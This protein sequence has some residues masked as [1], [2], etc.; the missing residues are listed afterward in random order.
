MSPIATRENTLRRTHGLFLGAGF[1][2]L[3]GLCLAMV[4]PY[5]MAVSYPFQ[6]AAAYAAVAACAWRAMKARSP[7][8]LGWWLV[9]LSLLLWAAGLSVS[10]WEDLGQHATVDFAKLSDL[11]YFLFGVPLLVA[12]SLPASG[13]EEKLFAWLDGLQAAITACAIYVAMFSSLPFVH[14]SNKPISASLL[15]QAYN[16]ENL[17][18]ASAATLRLLAEQTSGERRRLYGLLTGFLWCYAICAGWYNQTTIALQEQVGLYDLLVALPVTV[19]AVGALCVP[20]AT[21]DGDYTVEKR[22]LSELIDGIVPVLYTFALLTLGVF[23][24][25]THFYWGATALVVALAVFVIRSTV[26]HSRLLRSELAL[27][28]AHDRLEEIALTDALT[29]VANRRSFDRKLQEEWSRS[30]RSHAPLSLLLIDIDFFKPL[31]DRLGHQAGDQC[32]VRVAAA[33]QSTMLRNGDLLARYGGEEFAAILADTHRD[34]AEEVAARMQAAVRELKV[35]HATA[36]GEFV[37]VSIGISTCEEAE[38]EAF[39]WLVETADRALYL[40]KAR[41][42]NRVEHIPYQRV[43]TR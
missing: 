38:A 18:L 20:L 33:L 22:T 41:G 14:G 25:R 42:R 39:E 6:L 29:C 35:A 10:A 23:V 17:L 28:E 3:Y 8:Q 12:L 21:S 27:R 32:L 40:A 2:L 15:A 30:R 13:R 24:I 16:G 4:K 19:L 31:N 1:L 43:E 11:I 26:L 37:S 36:I 34:G 5:S 9:S 7:V